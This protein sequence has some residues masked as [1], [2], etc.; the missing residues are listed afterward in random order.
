[1]QS[2][3]TYTGHVTDCSVEIC[4]RLAETAGLC[5]AH[6]ERLRRTGDLRAELPIR[7]RSAMPTV[8][9]V[10][11]CEGLVSGGGLCAAHYAAAFS[12]GFRAFGKA[13]ICSIDDCTEP[14]RSRGYCSSHYNK[15]RR[16]GTPTPE[17]KPPPKRRQREKRSGYVL[18][19]APDSPMAM[20]NGYVPEHRMVMAEHLRRP[21]ERF[22]NVHHIN[23][24]RDDNRI[25]NLELWNTYQ[26]AGQ[27]VGD[28]VA[29]AVEILR[30][31]HP[32]SLSPDVLADPGPVS[33]RDIP[34]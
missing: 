25:E 6:S 7:A 29:W 2:S 34:A 15:F 24:V 32:D 14:V 16:W 23:G 12:R 18:V 13:A 19:K 5:H 26:P 8:C 27:R 20:V 9:T 33:V 31:Y 22:E 28:K 3:W 1:M 30:L 21:L 4:D 17:P 11:G 10:Q